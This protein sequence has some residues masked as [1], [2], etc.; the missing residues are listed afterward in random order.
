M[1]KLDVVQPENATGKAAEAY[2]VFPEGVPVPL[3]MVMMSASP[4]LAKLQSNVLSYYIQHP[5]LSTPLLACLRYLVA[6][7]YGYSFCIRFNGDILGSLGVSVVDLEAMED[8]PG[9]APLEE[10]E[11]ALLKFV[12]KAIRQPESIQDGD[13]DSLRSLGFSDQDVFDALWHGVGMIGPS[14]LFKA[15]ATLDA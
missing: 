8:N 13:I 2:A 14:I 15:L 6:A 7:D 9:A 5:N 4:D 1:F 11:K 10:R 12:L 3:P